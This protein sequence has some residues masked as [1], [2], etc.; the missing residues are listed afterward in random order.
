M[1]LDES[2]LV[3]PEKPTKI[4]LN[5]LSREKDVLEFAMKQ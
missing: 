4:L 3:V 1:I 2:Y 5:S